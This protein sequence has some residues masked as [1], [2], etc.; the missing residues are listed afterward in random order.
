MRKLILRSDLAL[1]D[2]VLM[3]AAVR[4]LHLCYPG[5]FLTDVRTPCGT[6]WNHNPYLCHLNE[7]EPEV[8]TLGLDL[9]LIDWSNRVPYHVLEGFIDNLNQQLG[10]HV[11]C[12]EFKGDIHLSAAEKRAPSP[13]H[14]L[15]GRKIP[16][17]LIFAGGRHEITIKWWDHARYQEVVDHFRGRIQFV[18]AG[19][20]SDH[21]PKLSGTIDLRGKSSVRE[22]LQLVYHSQGILCGVT[23]PMHLAAAVERKPGVAGVRPCVVVAGGRESAHWEAYPG[24]QFLHTIGA[25]PCCA[26]GGCWKMRT[27]PLGD[28]SPKDVS[29]ELCVNVKHGLPS[30]MD[31]VSAATVIQSVQS[32]FHG[33]VCQP[34]TRAE[35]AAAAKAIQRT[36]LNPIDA[37]PLTVAN[38]RFACDQFC[39]ALPKCPEGFRGRGI[40]LCIRGLADLTGAWICIRMLR[41]LGCGLPVELWHRPSQTGSWNLKELLNG[42]H[43]RCVALPDSG[44]EQGAA[45]RSRAEAHALSHCS[46]AEVL[47]LD[48]AIVPRRNPEYLFNLPPYQEAGLMVWTDSSAQAIAPDAWS[49]SGLAV[50]AERPVASTPM[51]LDKAKAWRGL[52]LWLW[53]HEQSQVYYPATHQ[54]RDTAHLAFRKAGLRAARGKRRGLG[55]LSDPAGQL[56]FHQGT[57]SAWSALFG[58]SAG[59]RLPW[60]NECRQYLEEF[61]FRCGLSLTPS[62]LPAGWK[63]DSAFAP[64]LSAPVPAAGRATQR[65]NAAGPLTI[66]TLHE[67]RMAGVGR[68]TAGAWREYAQRH[69]YAFVCHDHLLD[70]SRHPSWNKILAVREAMVQQGTGWVMWVDADA[71]VMNQRI[72]AESLIPPGCDLVTASDG[73]GLVVG[74]FL[75]RCCQWSLNFLETIFFLGDVRKDP[76]GYGPKWEQNTIKHVFQNFAGFDRHKVL[77]PERQLNSNL[78]SFEPG[79]FILHLGVMTN[80]NRERIAREALAWIVK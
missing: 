69:G 51:L 3:T 62:G 15:A 50:S 31:M 17:W 23:G 68:V 4:D 44:A 58:V 61:R 34:L 48:P 36:A 71:L 37:E 76:D 42:L 53:F 70:P 45:N 26:S 65:L 56:V 12:T 39:R 64:S 9:P 66:V 1:G 30:C 55:P 52:A 73:N 21:H 11:R 5:A 16:F 35:S 41:Q 10:L 49:L 46:F 33:L 27:V 13:V 57:E 25:L 59:R 22:L 67:E 80:G 40:V 24:H 19:S 43:V 74:I 78:R 77:L 29:S 18:Q 14:L 6:L 47:L 72:R 63:K 8:E 20:A 7:N 38:A 75:I 28:G 2:V 32:Y 60:Q 79:D 54:G